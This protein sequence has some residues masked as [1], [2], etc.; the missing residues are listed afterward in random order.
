MAGGAALAVPILQEAAAS[1]PSLAGKL[2][3]LRVLNGLARID[4]AGG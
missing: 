4:G 1:D 2:R 3:E